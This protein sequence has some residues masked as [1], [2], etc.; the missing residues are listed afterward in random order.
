MVLHRPVE[1]ARVLRE[2]QFCRPVCLII[3]LMIDKHFI[4]IARELSVCVLTAVVLISVWGRAD[5]QRN[6][7]VLQDGSV[8]FT[9][10]RRSFFAWPILVVYLIYATI[11]GVMHIQG[12]PLN[13]MSAVIIGILTGMIAVSFP[14]K[15]NRGERWTPTGLL[16]LEK[17]A[18][19]LGGHRRDQHRRKESHGDDHGF[20][21]NE[22]RPQPRFAR[23]AAPAD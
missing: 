16:A 20:G 23:Q 13:L 21:W 10:N 14:A 3:R 2:L 18:H 4:S 19:P 9:P 17:Q 6:A 7:G 12:S 8:E 11:S 15:N 22:D 1:T 5:R